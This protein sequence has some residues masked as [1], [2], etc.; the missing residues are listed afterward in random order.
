MTELES[1][2]REAMPNWGLIS[3]EGVLI[4]TPPT[5]QAKGETQ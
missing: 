1:I 3:S 5:E 4:V 2:I